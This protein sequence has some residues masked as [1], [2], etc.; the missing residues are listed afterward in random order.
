MAYICLEIVGDILFMHW[1]LAPPGGMY[2][3]FLHN[4]IESILPMTCIKAAIIQ[5]IPIVPIQLQVGKHI[6][7]MKSRWVFSMF[8]FVLFFLAILFC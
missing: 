3:Q 2:M 6:F 8:Y 7:L 4:I 1:Y 5:N